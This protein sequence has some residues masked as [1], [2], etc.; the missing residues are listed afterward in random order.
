MIGLDTTVLV[1]YLAQD[2]ELESALATALIETHLSVDQPGFVSALVL[3]E[4]HS[5]L[6]RLYGVDSLRFA[7]IARGLLTAHALRFDNLPAAWNALQAFEDGHGF[8]DA[9][10]AELADDAGCKTT[11]TFDS[12]LAKHPKASLLAAAR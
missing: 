7:D 2:D 9:L 6:T 1:R 10:L 4:L 5:V 3:A 11:V 8:V 12:H